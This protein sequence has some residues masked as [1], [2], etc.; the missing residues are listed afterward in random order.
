[1]AVSF[2]LLMLPKSIC[3][4]YDKITTMAKTNKK[5]ICM[6]PFTEV[7]VYENGNVNCCCLQYTDNFTFGNIFKDGGFEKV[8]NGRR[9]KAFR[10]EVNN[11]NYTFCNTQICNFGRLAPKKT[12]QNLNAE[13]PKY[14]TIGYDKTCNLMCTTCR[15]CIIRD[16]TMTDEELDENI[17]KYYLPICKNAEEL[18]LN[19]IGECLISKHSRRLIQKVSETY[20]NLKF[21]IMTN[22]TVCNEIV[23]KHL[24]LIGRLSTVQISI[25]A[26]TKKTYNK[27]TRTG[28]FDCVMKNLKWLSEQKKKGEIP[29]IIINFVTHKGNYKEMPAF[30]ELATKYDVTASFWEV[31]NWGYTKFFDKFDDNAVFHRDN[32]L[33]DDFLNVLKNP[34]FDS[35]NCLL[36]S[37]FT[38]LREEALQM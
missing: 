30:V 23:L 5:P 8:W 6:A 33:F 35:P 29:C 16:R 14:V 28:N 21:N 2:F 11:G 4:L 38:E 34:I 27:I 26:A 12:R 19:S 32:P 20:P 22:G 1:M 37:L 7:E 17:E 18:I 9:A 13:Y 31:Q 24:G 10:R 25:N 15:D 3:K 36:N